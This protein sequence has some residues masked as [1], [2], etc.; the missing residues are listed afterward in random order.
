MIVMK[1]ALLIRGEDGKKKAVDCEV[2]RGG[3][4]L[5]IVIKENDGLAWV[6]GNKIVI[7]ARWLTNHPPDLNEVVEEINR[8][9]LHEIIEH[10]CGLGHYIAVI[11]ESIVFGSP[12]FMGSGKKA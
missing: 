9:V 5:D 3:I 6:D 10:Y 12:W 11:A 4:D 2:G 1:P 7:N 8:S